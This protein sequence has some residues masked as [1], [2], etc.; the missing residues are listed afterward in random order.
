MPESNIYDFCYIE[1]KNLH[2]FGL[3]VTFEIRARGNYH[4]P[5]KNRYVHNYF[6]ET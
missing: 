1:N 3:G 2:K 5:N 4:L 6:Y